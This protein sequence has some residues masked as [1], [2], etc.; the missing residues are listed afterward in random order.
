MCLW[1]CDIILFWYHVISLFSSSIIFMAF[2]HTWNKHLTII[3]PCH[4]CTHSKKISFFTPDKRML[5]KH[6]LNIIDDN[7][8]NFAKLFIPT[9]FLKNHDMIFCFYNIFCGFT[10]YT[11]YQAQNN[12]HWGLFYGYLI[13]P[14]FLTHMSHLVIEMLL[15]NHKLYII[16]DN[17]FD[18]VE[19]SWSSYFWW[20]CCLAF[21]LV[22]VYPV[23]FFYIEHY[24]YC[25]LVMIVQV[26]NQFLLPLKILWLWQNNKTCLL[27]LSH[28]FWKLQF[29][30]EICYIVQPRGK[31]DT[32]V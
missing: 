21:H 2:I 12:Y 23:A 20:Y 29:T 6:N 13:Q 26:L 7:L 16:Q 3:V 8:F 19:L 5:Y 1:Y 11:D 32:E 25:C 28:D 22:R 30:S 9:I 14:L 31:T 17:L 27:A 24:S 15:Y 18:Y 10:S 4:G